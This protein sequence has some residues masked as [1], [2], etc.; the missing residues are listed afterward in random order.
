MSPVSQL[1]PTVGLEI[2]FVN[3]MQQGSQLIFHL[4]CAKVRYVLQ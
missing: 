3:S 1:A 2:N 4:W